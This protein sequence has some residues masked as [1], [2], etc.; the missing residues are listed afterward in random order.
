MGLFKKDPPKKATC[1]ICVEPVARDESL[2]WGKHITQIESGPHAGGYTWTCSCGPA[3]MGWPQ[4]F[5][6]EAA[7]RLHMIEKHGF[8]MG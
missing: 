5:A 6:A 2:H 1:P 7:L 8:S 4:D 3:N